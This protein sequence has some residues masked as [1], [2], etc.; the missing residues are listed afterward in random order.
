VTIAAHHVGALDLFRFSHG[1]F[2]EQEVSSGQWAAELAALPLLDL[3][4]RDFDSRSDDPSED[5]WSELATLERVE[6]YQATGFVIAQMDITPIEALTR[7][8]AYAF[9]HD[10]TASEVAF[11]II[12][13]SI[14]LH[15][16]SSDGPDSAS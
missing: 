11:G 2:N 1:P 7:I 3:M 15:D 13:H 10:L 12:D 8:R 14:S 5:G 16:D 9:A 6:V 4:G